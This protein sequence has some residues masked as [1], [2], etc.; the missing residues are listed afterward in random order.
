MELGKTLHLPNVNKV[1]KLLIASTLLTIIFITPMIIWF[2]KAVYYLCTSCLTVLWINVIWAIVYNRTGKFPFSS[3][4]ESQHYMEYVQEQERLYQILQGKEGYNI[5]KEATQAIRHRLDTL[6]KYL[7]NHITGADL[8][9]NQAEDE[10]EQMIKDRKA[11]MESTRLAYEASNPAFIKYLREKGLDDDQLNYCCLYLLGLRSKEIG[12]YLGKRSH[13][14]EASEIR[15][16]LGLDMGNANLGI[17]LRKLSTETNFSSTGIKNLDTMRKFAWSLS[18]ISVPAE[19]SLL[20]YCGLI[21]TPSEV[22]VSVAMVVMSLIFFTIL[23]YGLIKLR[24]EI[25]TAMRMAWSVPSSNYWSRF[26]VCSM[27]L[28]SEFIYLDLISLEVRHICGY[29]FAA[30]SLGTLIL[31][32]LVPKR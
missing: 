18:T 1:T 23:I 22:I 27:V 14:N 21:G 30:I 8:F 17:Y 3:R 4:K 26:W 10:S 20:A 32:A 28:F 7:A 24:K 29:I 25:Y 11:F 6:N 19:F 31:A 5:S 15:K 2:N 9:G 13:Y 12:A 16:K